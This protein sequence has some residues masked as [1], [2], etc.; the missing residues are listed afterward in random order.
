MEIRGFPGGRIHITD[1]E[2]VV[3]GRL[4]SG[5]VKWPEQ[6]VPLVGYMVRP[7]DEYA[8]NRWIEVHQQDDKTGIKRWYVSLGTFSNIG[9][10][11]Q[12]SSTCIVTLSR[13]GIRRRGLEQA[14]VKRFL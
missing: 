6:A 4:L 5:Y 13:V 12:I 8:R 11:S 2:S 10:A 14:S 7:N 3:K 1:L 9:R